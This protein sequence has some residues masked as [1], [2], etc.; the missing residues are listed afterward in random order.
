[1]VIGLDKFREFF[2]DFTSSYIII[3]GT[4]CDIILDDAGF[5]P[6]ATKDIDIIL[7]VEALE[8]EF[9]KQFWAFIKEADYGRKEKSDDKRK[10]YRFLNPKNKEFPKQVELF[11]RVPDI[12]LGEDSHLTPIPVDNDI[13]S[14]SAILLENDYYNYTIEHSTIEEGINIANTESLICLKAKAFI[15]MTEQEVQGVKVD[16]KN[17]RKHKTDIFRMAAM[18]TAED[19]FDLPDSIR[20]D[21][22]SFVN[23]VKDDLPDKNM[24]KQMGAPINDVKELF[25]QFL[26]NFKLNIEKP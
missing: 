2:K 12:D 1:M 9:I 20:S 5:T 17:I 16:S 24:F 3:G 6:R 21:M 18:L 11:S 15:D 14:L 7:I 25:N 4:A 19:E 23:I 10:Y 13:S 22:Q 26:A 8:P